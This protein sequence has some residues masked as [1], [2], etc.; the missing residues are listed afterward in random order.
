MSKKSLPPV[1]CF[2]EADPLQ[3]FYCDMDGAQYNVARLIDAAKGLEPFDMPLAGI[4]TGV[5]IWQGSTIFD[6]AFHCKKV[7]DADL[8][9]PII[10][11]WY[12]Q[13]ADGRHRI[14]KA[15]V[16][17]K[18]TIKAVRITWR[19]TPCRAAPEEDGKE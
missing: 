17:G 8:D 11:D 1:L 3:D 6:L 18:R 16:E 5:A 4:D 13:V 9:V 19:M 15:L 10:L 2:R 12:G 14:I 7:F